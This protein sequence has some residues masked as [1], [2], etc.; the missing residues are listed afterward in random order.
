VTPDKADIVLTTYALIQRDKDQLLSYTFY[1]LVMDEAQAIKNHKTKM[2]Q[3]ALQLDAH[4]RLCLTGTPV[5]NH[6]GE[7]WSLFNFLMPGFLGNQTRFK[8]VFRTPIERYQNQSR[9]EQLSQRIKP[10]LLRR[11]KQQVAQEI[12]AKSEIVHTLEMANKQ[13]DLYESIRVSMKQKVQQ[14]IAEKGLKNSQITIL[15][16][17]LKLRQICCDPRMLPLEQAKNFQTASP[18]LQALL[19]IIHSVR[20]EGRQVV[21][22]SQFVKMLELIQQALQPH[23]ISFETLT[24]ETRHR[25]QAVERFQQGQATVFLVSLKAGGTGLNLTAADTVVHFDPWWNPSVENQATDRTHRIG[26]NQ[27]VFVYK[28][29]MKGSVEEKVYELQQSKNTLIEGLFNDRRSQGHQICEQDI[30]QL[31]Q[32]I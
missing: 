4:H 17:L 6:L 26:Q 9:H 12:P 8:Q 10:F 5:E 3:V 1:L 2:A 18:K 31:F 27:N 20:E 15:D 23:G 21:V 22:F 19:E 30:E 14:A 28:L 7:L 16:A 11:T 13:R 25:G 24:G 32:P 29:L